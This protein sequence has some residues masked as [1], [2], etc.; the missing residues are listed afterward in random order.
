MTKKS[1]ISIDE[2]IPASTIKD[3]VIGLLKADKPYPLHI[4][5]RWGI[6]TFGMKYAIDVVILDDNFTVQA[7]KTSLEP[8]RIFLWNP[9]FKHVLELPEGTIQNKHITTNSQLNLLQ[10]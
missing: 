5:T 3:R 6:H 10:Y 1:A 2:V 9:K 7:I 8:W 4:K